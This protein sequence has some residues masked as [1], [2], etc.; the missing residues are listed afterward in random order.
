MRI[1]KSIYV[2]AIAAVTLASCGSLKNMAVPTMD[3]AVSIATKKGVVSEEQSKHWAHADLA[4]DTIP[5][6]SIDKAYKFLEGK[7]GEFFE[8]STK[9]IRVK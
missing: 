3:T 4:T 7:T 1:F 9:K 5:G 6:M 8:Q 2:T